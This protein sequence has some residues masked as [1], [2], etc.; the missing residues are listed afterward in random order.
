MKGLSSKSR[1]S[2][3]ERANADTALLESSSVVKEEADGRERGTFVAR[4]VA[5]Q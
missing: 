3:A 2:G 4:G 5:V 1:E